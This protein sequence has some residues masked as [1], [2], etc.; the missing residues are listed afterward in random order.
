[1]TFLIREAQVKYASK[2]A[3]PMNI[4]D[5]GIRAFRWEG[6]ARPDYDVMAASTPVASRVV[7]ADRSVFRWCYF[8]SR[9]RIICLLLGC[10]GAEYWYSH[11]TIQ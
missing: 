8:Y 1:M 11:T 3:E 7:A 4:A 2:P 10:R 6:M 5:E 9:G